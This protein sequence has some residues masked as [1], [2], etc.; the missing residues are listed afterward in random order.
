MAQGVPAYATLLMLKTISPV[1]EGAMTYLN[2]VAAEANK[3]AINQCE[4]MEGLVGATLSM[5][6][7]GS[8]ATRQS[9]MVNSGAKK[10]MSSIQDSSL[11]DTDDSK[12][13]A[14]EL[15]SLLGDNYNLV[16][17]ALENKSMAASGDDHFR[18]LLM[19][20]SGTII[21]TKEN[22][23]IAIVHKNSLVS[24]ELIKEFIGTSQGESKLKLYHCD[25][26][27]LCLK[28][29]V[30]ETGRI[31][32]DDTLMG[33]V[34]NLLK[35]IAE[36]VH[37]NKGDANTINGFT[38]D[39]ESLISLATIPIIRKMEMDLAVYK[40]A[41]WAVHAQ[42]EF[43]EALCYDVVTNYLAAL[44][45]E[46]TMAVGDM[47]R[48]QLTNMRNF[49]DRCVVVPAMIGRQFTKEELFVTNDIWRLVSENAGTISRV[50]LTINGVHF[51]PNCKEAVAYFEGKFQ[52]SEGRFINRIMNKFR[53]AGGDTNTFNQGTRKLNSNIKKSIQAIY[54]AGSEQSV[55]TILKHNMMINS[56]NDYRAGK[57]PNARAQM[58]A[59]AGGLLSGDMAEKTLTGSLA[60]MKVLM[61]GSFIFLLPLLILTGGIK[62]YSMW[63]MAAFSLQLWPPLFS[64]LN[65]IIDVAYDPAEIVSYSSWSTEVK[66]FDSIAATAANMTLMIPF[67]A[68]WITKLGEGGLMHLAGSIMA[69]ANSAVGAIAGEKSSGT[70]A[71]DNQNIRNSSRDMNNSGKVDHNMQ[72]ASGE[73]SYTTGDGTRVKIGQDGSAI[74]NSGVGSTESS[75][76]ASY[77]L[78]SG[79]DASL[80]QNY[81]E[82]QAIAKS[83]HNSFNESEMNTQSQGANYL[84]QIAQAQKASKGKALDL[85]TEEGRIINQAL[86]DIGA[87][88]EIDSITLEENAKVF[89]GVGTGSAVPGVQIGVDTSTGQSKNLTFGKEHRVN[90]EQDISKSRNNTLKALSSASFTEDY[91]STNSLG[92]EYRASYD[93]TKKLEKD[94]S[95]SQE[96]V[97][98]ASDAISYNQNH[99]AHTNQ[100]VYQDVLDGVI[101]QGYSL[102]DAKEKVD[103]R[104]EVAMGVFNGLVGNEVHQIKS[105]IFKNKENNTSPDAYKKES[106][107]FT[108]EH[109]GEI[110]KN[111]GHE[112]VQKAKNDGLSKETIQNKQEDINKKTTEAYNSNSAKTEQQYNQAQDAI[113][114]KQEL[115]KG[116]KAK[117]EKDNARYAGAKLVYA[118]KGG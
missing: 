116:K 68:M 48:L 12:D 37:N 2:D 90:N 113:N 18:E 107:A 97:K 52:D 101:K 81:D 92:E 114:K 78:G 16:W 91:E 3:L 115:L 96:N 112:V 27:S 63:I 54:G 32:A 106:K 103:N 80:Q 83:A 36:K 56:L 31:K 70:V 118:K 29:E 51:T 26:A 82:K 20:I 24:K 39:E 4:A 1:I 62:K 72:Y 58:H 98:S 8:K 7:A 65:M 79:V 21:G 60:V 111:I 89:F 110:K 55:S 105:Q 73:Q 71:Y 57:F 85:S 47:S 35:S 44:L 88:S 99:S 104:K 61:Y 67:L 22:N 87:Y 117:P 25:T 95:I 53:G 86:I 34:T 40:D 59:E 46:V 66:K 10:D 9:A 33:Q 28:P 41:A 108:N 13:G 43:V 5:V 11:K 38:A 74:A 50:D 64:M 45:N 42:S 109:E 76:K 19:S 14:K 93:K 49:I 102:T 84:L 100:D 77:I 75:G 69:T 30:R 15:E 17:K 6:N 23:V 94:V